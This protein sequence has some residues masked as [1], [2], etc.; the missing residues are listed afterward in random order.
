MPDRPDC[1]VAFVADEIGLAES[2]GMGAAPISSQEVKAWCDMMGET[3]SP[4]E[5]RMVRA[6]SRAYCNGIS[7]KSAPHEPLALK[8][9]LASLGVIASG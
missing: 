5:F 1:P 9:G 8:L 6:M 3:L 4:W 2:G 7:A